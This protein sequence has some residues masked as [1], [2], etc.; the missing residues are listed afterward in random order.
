MFDEEMGEWKTSKTERK[1]TYVST[2]GNP[3][4]KAILGSK[5]MSDA[6]INP[7]FDCDTLFS[8]WKQKV[9]VEYGWGVRKFLKQQ[10]EPI[11]ISYQLLNKQLLNASFNQIR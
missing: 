6:P 10:Q 8:Y 11:E 1:R 2:Y 3:N 7:D 5:K 9:F 4:W